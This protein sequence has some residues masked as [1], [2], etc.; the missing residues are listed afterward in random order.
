MNVVV[1]APGLYRNQGPRV[2][3][4]SDIFGGFSLGF[5]HRRSGGTTTQNQ[6]KP[7]NLFYLFIILFFLLLFNMRTL[8]DI[9]NLFI[10]FTKILYVHD[11]SESIDD[12]DK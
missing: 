4:T 2:A 5:D 10:G 7:W 9:D 11:C 12:K 3:L 1:I 8:S 6:Q